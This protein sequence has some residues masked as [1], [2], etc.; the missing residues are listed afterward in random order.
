[1]TS[2]NPFSVTPQLVDPY[3]VIASIYD[4]L[5]QHVAYPQWAEYI[6]KVFEEHDTSVRDIIE[7]A[8][9]TGKLAFNLN[10]MGYNITGYDRSTAM[11][12]Q[13][14]QNY[15]VSGLSFR[16]GS[17][18]DF[19]IEEKYDAAICLYDSI[20][21]ILKL[22]GVNRFIKRVKTVVKPGGLFIFD[23]CTRYNSKIH[24]RD[25][26]DQGK[27]G[28]YRYFRYSNYSPKN[29]FHIN[30]FQIYDMDKPAVRYSEKHKQMIYAISDIR[31]AVRNTGMLIEAEYDDITFRKVGNQ[32]LRVHFVLRSE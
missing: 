13:A 23:I 8:C 24:F 31:K 1:M 26:L 18:D 10:K 17:F 25:F 12:E 27:I 19:P 15:P 14:K 21:Y 3:Q 2:D 4:E 16:I 28:N 7:L 5:M 29:H 11:L 30:E 20:N 9:G 32:S 22:E 6:S